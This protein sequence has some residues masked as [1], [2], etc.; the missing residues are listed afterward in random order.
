MGDRYLSSAGAGRSCALPMRVPN[1]S[2]VLEKN[3]APIGPG[4]LS[5][6]GAGVWRRG[7]VVFPDS[8][9]VL[10]KFQF[11]ILVTNRPEFVTI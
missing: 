3:L 2:P 10:H 4:I 11:V 6:I 7:P 1:T 9:S 5:S 8:S